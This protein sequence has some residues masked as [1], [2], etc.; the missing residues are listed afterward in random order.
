MV[1]HDGNFFK[2][3]TI[4]SQ[5]PVIAFSL[6]ETYLF[7]SVQVGELHEKGF[8]VKNGKLTIGYSQSL[9]TLYSQY[10]T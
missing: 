2:Y 5:M 3:K 7:D 4:V 8:V 1:I 6:Q 10:N 9:N